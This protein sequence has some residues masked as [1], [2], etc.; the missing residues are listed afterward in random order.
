MEK[1]LRQRLTSWI[2]VSFFDGRAFFKVGVNATK[3]GT[4]V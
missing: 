2:L 4:V 3:D 1:E